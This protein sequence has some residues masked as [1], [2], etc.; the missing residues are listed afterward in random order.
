MQVLVQE[1]NDEVTVTS[2]YPSSNSYA[3]IA[4]EDNWPLKGITT[5][6]MALWR[7]ESDR[8]TQRT[9]SARKP[10]DRLSSNPM[11]AGYS[12]GYAVKLP[13]VLPANVS[14]YNPDS[15]WCGGCS[16]HSQEGDN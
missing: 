16:Y 15:K 12:N 1:N 14:I 13:N 6:M 10:D 8:T 5:L 3:T 4:F 2:V 7:F 9:T 11:G